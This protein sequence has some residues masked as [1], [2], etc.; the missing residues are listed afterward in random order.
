LGL[1]A[2]RSAESMPG[3]SGS[4]RMRKMREI[5]PDITIV[6]VSGYLNAALVQRAREAGADEVLKKRLSAPDLATSLARVLQGHV[7]H[8]QNTDLSLVKAA[9]E[10]MPPT[11]VSS[12]RARPARRRKGNNL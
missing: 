10:A 9:A 1:E 5:R 12:Q 3:T 8:A 6:L 4:E 7:E 11:P 2:V